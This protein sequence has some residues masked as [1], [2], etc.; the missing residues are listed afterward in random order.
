MVGLRLV[1]EPATLPA[2]LGAAVGGVLAYW[3]AFYA[4]VL[5]PRERAL[6]RGLIRRR[7]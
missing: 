4:L 6:V 2:V 1:A 3:L 5:D 7:A